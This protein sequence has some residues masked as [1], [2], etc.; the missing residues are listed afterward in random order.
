MPPKPKV[1]KYAIASAALSLVRS[2]GVEALNARRLASELGC[3][4]Q[5]V[6][7]NFATM[8]D[9]KNAVLDAANSI[10]EGYISLTSERDDMPQ[11]KASG[12][13]LIRFAAE[14]RELFKLLFMRDRSGEEIGDGREEL[15]PMIE[16][17]R[18]QTG[19]DEESAFRFHLEMWV[20]VHGIATMIATG[21]LNWDEQLAGDMLSDVYKGLE[22]RYKGDKQ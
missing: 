18:R 21:F 1:T 17:I 16:M 20:F 4:T 22:M 8:D 10:Y 14:E 6:F 15:R 2:E 13:G 12:L 19:I 3:S 7:S 5:P 9:L 11:Y